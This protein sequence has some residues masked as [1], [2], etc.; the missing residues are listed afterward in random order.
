[1]VKVARAVPV[2]LPLPFTSTV[3]VPAFTLF[4]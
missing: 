3:A 2:Q 4:W 1:M